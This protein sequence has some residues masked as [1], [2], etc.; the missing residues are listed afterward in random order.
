MSYAEP[1]PTWETLEDYQTA[2]SRARAYSL[3]E[4]ILE[5][6]VKSYIAGFSEADGYFGYYSRA[7]KPYA[8][9]VYVVHVSDKGAVEYI[10][11]AIRRRM[12]TVKK[13]PLR[14]GTTVIGLSAIIFYR[15]IEPALQGHGREK[16]R[17]I[18][19]HGFKV[20]KET[21]KQFVR[22][23]PFGRAYKRKALLRESQKPVEITI[24]ESPARP[25]APLLE[26]KGMEQ[27]ITR[28]Y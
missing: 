4:N 8:S 12:W 23:F 21:P 24:Y 2:L 16:T 10:S 13:R 14:Y 15:I 20:S 28:H 7:D 9:P 3:S 25:E 22:T 6:D 5:T 18:I 19:R 11:R 27:E 1:L 17:F 26:L